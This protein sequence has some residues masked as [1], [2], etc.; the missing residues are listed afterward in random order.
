MPRTQSPG[1]QVLARLEGRACAFCST[2]ELVRSTYKGNDAVVCEDC[3][4][5]RVQFW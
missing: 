1:R 5:P 4:T 2:G 3:G